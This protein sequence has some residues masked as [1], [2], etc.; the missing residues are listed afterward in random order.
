VKEERNG[1]EGSEGRCTE[2]KK[3]GEGSK[4]GMKKGK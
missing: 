1:R 4:E 2:G 3:E